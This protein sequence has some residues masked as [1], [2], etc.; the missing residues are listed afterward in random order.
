V[1]HWGGEG[2]VNNGN[3]SVLSWSWNMC[4]AFQCWR[5][6]RT[7]LRSHVYVQCQSQ[8][9]FVVWTVSAPSRV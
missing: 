3:K 9:C 2:G 6:T 8:N 7:E 1:T 4:S 5:Y